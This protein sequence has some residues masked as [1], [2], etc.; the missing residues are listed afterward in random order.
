MIMEDSQGTV[1]HRWLTFTHTVAE[2][3]KKS[4]LAMAQAHL[5]YINSR[6]DRQD[7]TFSKSK[8][9][10]R[11]TNGGKILHENSQ[12]PSEGISKYTMPQHTFPNC[13]PLLIQSAHSGY[14]NRLPRIHPVC[15]RAHTVHIHTHYSKYLKF[16][17]AS[18]KSK[19][20]AKPYIY[21]SSKSQQ[22]QMYNEGSSSNWE[23]KHAGNKSAAL[24]PIPQ[25]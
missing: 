23:D 10:L 2:R 20:K 11:N 12:L 18:Y 4:F 5:G 13:S 24:K 9:H 14:G 1:R 17:L 22:K 15:E 3:S 21:D 8:L 6:H 19:P 25:H 7:P 16:K